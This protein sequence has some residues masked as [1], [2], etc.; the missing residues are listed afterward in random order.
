VL[1]DFA[2]FLRAV[3]DEW[4]VLLTGGTIIA[5]LALWQMSGRSVPRNTGWLVIGL[6]LIFASFL[7]WRKEWIQNGRGFIEVYPE[8][9][10]RLVRGGMT[11]IYKDSLVKPYLHKWITVTGKLGNVAVSVFRLAVYI[12]LECNDQ[13][14]VST[15][16]G[17]WRAN[18]FMPLRAGTPI[19][20]VGRIDEIQPYSLS[21]TNAEFVRIEGRDNPAHD[22][23]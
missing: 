2:N 21:L 15:T 22:F 3:W 18:P 23:R 4:K 17:R 5:I 11:D 19:T 1:R 6:T 9:L 13:V 10:A 12:R 16:I 8:T 14:S 7:A 20:I